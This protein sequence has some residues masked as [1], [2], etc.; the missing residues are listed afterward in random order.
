MRIEHDLLGERE[1]PEDAYYG[2][3]TLRAIENFSITG[4]KLFL[5]PQLIYA[6]AQVKTA[7]DISKKL[8]S[9]SL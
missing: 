8:F 5:Y 7:F 4:I 6:L 2:I 3:Q 1:I 9:H